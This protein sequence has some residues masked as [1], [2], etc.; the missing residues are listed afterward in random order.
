[1]SERNAPLDIGEH[2]VLPGQK[3]YIDLPMGRLVTGSQLA[4]PL[5]VINGA[6]PGPA[7]WLSAAI[8][9]DEINGVEAIRRVLDRVKAKAL[10]GA[11]VAVPI[12]NVLGFVNQSRYLPDRR[13]LNRSFPGSRRGSLASRIAHL[14]M[15]EVVT[16]CAYGI[17]LHTGSQ[18]RTNLPQIRADLSDPETRRCALAFGAPVVIDSRVR[19]GSLREAA[20]RRGVH[21]LLYEGGEALRFERTPIRVAERGVLSVMVELGMLPPGAVEAGDVGFVA[22]SSHWIRAGKSGI[23][24][25]DVELGETV[26]AGQTI[27]VVTD[28]FGRMPGRARSPVAGMVIGHTTNP[29]VNRGDAIVHVALA[30]AK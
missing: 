28:A 29:L 9:G 4:L 26:A 12:V 25:L 19:D 16:K 20:K 7:V 24:H 23:L 3:R 30:P 13:D 21:V 6:R 8:H 10:A 11:I 2:R 1:M 22:S 18:M 15:N 27:G 14:F 5:C 17:D